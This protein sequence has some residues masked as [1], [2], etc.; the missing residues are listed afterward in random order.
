VDA[1][2]AGS[3]PD[4]RRLRHSRVVRS[5]FL[6]RTVLGLIRTWAFGALLLISFE[7]SA[8]VS[9]SAEPKQGQADRAALDR[10]LGA[11]AGFPVR[12]SP[13]P[14]VLLEGSVLA[15]EL[16]FPDDSSKMAFG[17]GEITAPTSWP[18]A[19]QSAMSLPIVEAPEAFT[20]LTTPSST[21][22]GTP[23]PL[24]V[25]GVQLGSGLFLTDRGWRELPAWLFSFSGVQNPAKVLAVRPT[26]IFS[27][28]VARDGHSPAQLSVTVTHGGRHIVANFA[29]APAGTGPCTA[30][31]TLSI[32]ESEQAVAVAVMTHSHGSGDVGCAA[33]GYLRHAAAEL[34]APLGARVVVDAHSEGAAAATGSSPV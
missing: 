17:N 12:S 34:K 10:A 31:Y 13:R 11:W 26:N 21:I 18:I 27:A 30:S 20:V 6:L 16:G 22:L 33:V 32:K 24:T 15:P 5:I 7:A 25:T 14:I 1:Q 4:G 9:A 2:W 29:G 3:E 23:P 28:P 19:P 8:A